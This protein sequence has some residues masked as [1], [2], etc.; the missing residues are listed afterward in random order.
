MF[1]APCKMKAHL[2]RIAYVAAFLA[3]MSYAFFTLRGPRGIP[4]LLERQRQIQDMQE[5]N[6]KLDK[7]IER[8]RDHIKRLTDNPAQQELEIRERLKLVKPGE[9]V[10]ITGD[11]A[12]Q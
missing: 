11:P 4:A 10:Y 5:R 6:A 7:E 8:M 2:A 1:Q 12:K 3:V 9:K